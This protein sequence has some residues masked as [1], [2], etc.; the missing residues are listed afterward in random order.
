MNHIP[1]S[2]TWNCSNQ[3]FAFNFLPRFWQKSAHWPINVIAVKLNSRH[4]FCRRHR[5]LFRFV[6]VCGDRPVCLTSTINIQLAGWV[7]FFLYVSSQV[8]VSSIWLFYEFVGVMAVTAPFVLA[9]AVKRACVAYLPEPF[10]GWQCTSCTYLCVSVHIIWTHR[11]Y[12]IRQ[13]FQCTQ[14]VQPHQNRHAASAEKPHQKLSALP[15]IIMMSAYC[16]SVH[17]WKNVKCSPLLNPCR[18]QCVFGAAQNRRHVQ[19]HWKRNHHRIF[20]AD[21]SH[22]RSS[23]QFPWWVPSKLFLWMTEWQ[24]LCCAPLGLINAG[25]LCREAAN[26]RDSSKPAQLVTN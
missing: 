1:S 8:R 24:K 17:I 20:P 2:T 11:P 10:M 16:W 12:T 4:F 3:V 14:K 19:M 26:Q 13:T 23:T 21:N 18:A 22:Q 7:F 15:C 6:Y 5:L 9:N 25:Q